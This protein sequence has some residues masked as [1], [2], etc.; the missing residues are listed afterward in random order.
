MILPVL[1]RTADRADAGCFSGIGKQP[2]L[3]AG[4]IH[5]NTRTE[6]CTFHSAN[7][8]HS[9]KSNK[10]QAAFEYAKSSL[11]LFIYL[12]FLNKISAKAHRARFRAAGLRTEAGKQ[13]AADAVRVFR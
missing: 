4:R 2:A 5:C 3:F 11:H 6:S 13:F 1:N 7:P 10:V 8:V 9:R 12:I